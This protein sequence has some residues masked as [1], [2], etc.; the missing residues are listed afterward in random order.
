MERGVLFAVLSVVTAFVFAASVFLVAGEVLHRR[1]AA[2]AAQG[3]KLSVS[4]L[5][6]WRLRN[7]YAVLATP[8]RVILRWTKVADVV[9]E[10]AYLLECRGMTVTSE[11]LMSVV[12]AFV[13]ALGCVVGLATASPIAAVA[14]LA[15]VCA[16]MVLAVGNARD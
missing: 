10:A 14:V 16:L 4:N 11:S 13:I 8:A 3:E 12:I 7:G 2:L 1:K 15:C 5:V 6:L 9:D